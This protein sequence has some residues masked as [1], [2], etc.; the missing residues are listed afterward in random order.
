MQLI[1][2]GKEIETK[3]NITVLKLLRELKVE[4]KTMAVAV[5][6]EVVKKESWETFI[7]KEGKKVEFLQ[8]VGGG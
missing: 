8:F 4:S 3:E 5:N 6:M 1:V 7:L 2:N